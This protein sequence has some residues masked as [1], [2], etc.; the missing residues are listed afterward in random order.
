[1]WIAL[2]ETMTILVTGIFNLSVPVYEYVLR[3]GLLNR[4]DCVCI[5]RQCFIYTETTCIYKAKWKIKR[6]SHQISYILD[7]ISAWYRLMALISIHINCF[8]VVRLK[9]SSFFS[10]L[11]HLPP[12]RSHCVGGCWNRT[13]DSCDYCIGSQTLG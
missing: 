11:F 13:Q 12:L 9:L 3:C 8:L 2:I 10:T 7:K 5:Q 4:W 6:S 1:V